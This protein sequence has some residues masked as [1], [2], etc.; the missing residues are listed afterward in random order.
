MPAFARRALPRRPPSSRPPRLGRL[1]PP[2]ARRRD[3]G[4]RHDVSRQPDAGA[5]PAGGVRRSTAT[6]GL[7]WHFIP[8]E[9]FPRKG[10]LIRE[11]T[12]PQRD[13]RARSAEERAQ[14]ARL[15]DRVVDHGSRNRARR[16]RGGA[17][18]R[19]RR[20]RRAAAPL[21]RDPEKYFFSVFGTPS[22]KDTWGW[23]VEGHH[24]S[25]HFT[26]VNG[27]LVAASPSFF[28]MQPGRSA[29]GAEEG[30]ADSRRRGGRGA[31]AARVARRRA[32]REGD[33]RRRRRRATW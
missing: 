21:E 9:T 3:G 10:L 14:P 15:P 25:L 28:G 7:H 27:T 4:G 8:T 6:S 2:S 12:E 23:R 17:A 32:A 31:R 18:R 19:R 22:A 13:A 30:A 26:V 16:A 29:R 11:M 1:P 20:S 24:V 33:H 5:A